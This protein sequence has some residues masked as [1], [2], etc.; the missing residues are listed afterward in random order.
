MC[1]WRNDQITPDQVSELARH[2]NVTDPT[3][4]RIVDALVRK[5]YVAR[6]PDLEDRR[7]IFLEITEQGTHLA[8]HVSEHLHRAI[9]RFLS[10]LTEEQLNDLA[11]LITPRDAELQE[12]VVKSVAWSF[13]IHFCDWGGIA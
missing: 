3:M 12:R 7:C 4:S 2:Y 6:R 1:P 11:A 9:V 10:A 8:G 5:G 13:G